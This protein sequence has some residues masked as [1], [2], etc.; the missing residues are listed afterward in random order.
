MLLLVDCWWGWLDQ[1]FRDWLH[2]NHPYILLLICPAKCTP[3]GQ[4]EDNGIIAM[5]KG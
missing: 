2:L 5:L 4:P 1:D 3:V